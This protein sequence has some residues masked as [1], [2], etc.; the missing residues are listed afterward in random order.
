MSLTWSEGSI[1]KALIQ[2]IEN[3]EFKFVFLESN[4]VKKWEGGNNRI[5][6]LEQIINLFEKEKIVDDKITLDMNTEIYI[7]DHT[8]CLL[9]VKCSWIN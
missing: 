3:V 8:N 2:A 4:Q 9:T 1:W 5:L 7:Y 6:N